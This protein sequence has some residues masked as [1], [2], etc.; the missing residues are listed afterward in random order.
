MAVNHSKG[1]RRG[2]DAWLAGVCSGMADFLGWDAGKIR[3]LWILAGFLSAGIPAMI[4]Y[5]IL[6][7]LMAPAEQGEFRLETSANSR[8]RAC[9]KLGRFAVCRPTSTGQSSG[10]HEVA[11]RP[12]ALYNSVVSFSMIEQE[13]PMPISRRSA[14][15]TLTLVVLLLPLNAVTAQP[16]APSI[17]SAPFVEPEE[18]DQEVANS[19]RGRV[20]I[21]GETV[22]YMATVGDL[23]TRYEDG[24]KAG[25]AKGRFT[26]V[27]YVRTGVEAGPE[28]RPVTFA[29][30][31]GP[32]SASVWVHLGLYG[33]KRAQLD[34]EGF[35]DTPAPGRLIDN[36]YSV[37]DVSDLVFIDP[38]SSGF[39]RPAP[40]VEESEFYG[41]S[42]DVETIAEFIRLWITRNERWA[43]PKFVAGESYGTT[44]AAG[45]ARE[46][47]DAHGMYLNGIVLI[48]S[49]L[50]WGTKVFNIGNDLPHLLILP[51]M[52]ASAW[53][54][55]K[56]GDEFQDLE[57]AL[58][59]AESFVLGPYASAL[60]LGRDI[61]RADEDR[62]VGDI[63]RLTGLSEQYVR[64]TN[65]R[66]EIMRFTKELLRTEGKTVGRLD[67]RYTGA[68][69]DS[70]GETFEYD[71]S[72]AVTSGWYV[73]LMNDYLRR[74]LGYPREI[75]FR[76]SAGG[77]VR[78]WNYHERGR[79]RGYN[80]NGY[81]NYAETLRAAMVKNPTL[82]V[83]VQSGYY[84][85]A[86]PYFATDYTVSH[87]GLPD[88][89]VPNLRVEYYEAGHM[90]Y[91]RQVD[92]E[93]SRRD[94]VDFVGRALAEP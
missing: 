32:L 10:N 30:N 33:P 16:N 84:D 62:I 46:L 35:P 7:W 71:P 37:L 94:F 83:L 23:V 64:E 11:L 54:H 6:A 52:T 91:M 85:L 88:E 49:V 31:G 74:D 59:E 40:G 63:A 48:S 75:R 5:A 53:Y 56:L 92:H 89:L 43:S 29:F 17:P 50:D 4:A 87:L 44:R 80:T 19:T 65:M 3:T 45:L 13:I 39:S 82:H 55:G 72:G 15:V 58:D 47:Q 51:T 34:A 67:S 27:S 79:T 57:D 1:M 69:L 93:K 42:N 18:F 36:P 24:D 38:V 26:Y 68:D 78:P 25:Q 14:A 9:E 41:F 61:T 20:V 73:S 28:E 22:N 70:A 81:A 21:D 12:A 90:F 60:M 86:T 66:P 77:R 76:Q 2:R 8:P